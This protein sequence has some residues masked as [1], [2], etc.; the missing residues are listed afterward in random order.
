VVQLR[1]TD[2]ADFLKRKRA[3]A[4]GILLYGNDEAAVGVALRHVM[5][6]FTDGEEALRLEASQ[7]RSDPAMLDDAFRAMSLLGDRRLIVV[8]DVDDSHL[9][10]IAPVVEATSPGNFVALTAGSLKKDSKLRLAV[11]RSALFHAVPL[12]AETGGAVVQ[13]VEALFRHLG[14]A[15]EEDAVERFIALCGEDRSVLANEADKLAL[16]CYPSTQVSVQDVEAACGDQA[17]FEA[18]QLIT[19]VLDGDL[20]AVDRMFTSLTQTGDAKSS[21]IMVQMHLARLESVAAAMARGSDLVSACRTARPPIFD[22]QQAA[23]G[24]HLRAFSGDDLGRAQT[25]V[26][27]AM[28]Q[29]RQMPDLGDAIT[30]RCLLSLARMARQLRA[31]AA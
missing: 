27:A 1:E 17:S 13:R 12:Y 10:A 22:K 31:K 8:T 3:R 11:E 20:E 18:D 15:P 6:A 16:Y 24:R 26:Q 29:A 4:S 9:A 21:L 7:L 5:V 25:A 2:L 19:V 14:L 30:G 23:A 28:L